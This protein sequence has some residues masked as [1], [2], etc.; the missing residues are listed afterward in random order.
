MYRC[1]G[2]A[3]QAPLEVMIDDWRKTIPTVTRDQMVEV[4]R[5]MIEDF[6]IE[7]LQMME[8]AGR[9]LAQLA[10]DRFLVGDARGKEVAVLAGTGGN[11]GGALVAARRLHDWGANVEVALMRPVD[12]YDGVPAHQLHIAQKM[13]IR[14]VVAKDAPLGDGP[15][16]ILDGMVGYSLRGRPR[17]VIADTVRWAKA[18]PAP[19]LALDIPTGLDATTGET[20]P[21]TVKATATMTLAL[22]KAGLAVPGAEEFTGQLYLAD[23]GVPDAVYRRLGVEA[24]PIFFGSDL[25]RL[26]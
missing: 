11:G 4:D 12:A 3:F 24:G 25:L 13:G 23:I 9:H 15:E 6:G 7:L 17:G 10:R 22:P 26:S 21:L 16:L 5:S 18:Q 1:C 8:N 20:S 14:F 19:V 2:G